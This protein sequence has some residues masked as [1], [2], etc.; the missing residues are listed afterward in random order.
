[1]AVRLTMI[2]ISF[3]LRQLVL[4]LGNILSLPDFRLVLS[5]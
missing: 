1:M 2:A 5:I 4:Y 3:E